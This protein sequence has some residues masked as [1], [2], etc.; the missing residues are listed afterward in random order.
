[1]AITILKLFAF[2]IS[3]IGTWEFIRRRTKID[4]NFLPGLT[5]AIQVAILF[6]AGLCHVLKIIAVVIWALGI[7]YFIAVIISDKNINFI[8]N[9][10]KVG[11]LFLFITMIIMVI[12]CVGKVYTTW[13]NFSH[14][15]IVVKQMFTTNAFPNANDAVIFYKEYPLGS[16]LYIY[17]F[18]GFISK[19]ESLQLLAQIY[20]IVVSVMPVFIFAKK[21]K[22]ASLIATFSFTNLFLVYNIYVTDLSVDTLLGIVG[23]STLFFIYTYCKDFA[24]LELKDKW[25]YAIA[26]GLYLIWVIQIK[27]SGIFFIIIAIIWLI[28]RVIKTKDLWARLV[29]MLMPIASLVAWRIHCSIAFID[30]DTSVHAMTLK[31]FINVFGT[32]SVSD[33]KKISSAFVSFALTYKDF[34]ITLALIFIIGV[35]IFFL[36]KSYR[37]T[38]L[39]LF[40]ASFI[41]YVL[42]QIGM[43]GMYF[44]SM[45]LSEALELACITRYTKTILIAMIFI[46][47][48]MTT[49]LISALEVKNILH[50][51]LII[52]AVALPIFFVKVCTGK[53]KFAVQYLDYPMT[54]KKKVEAMKD[55]YEIEEGSSYTFLRGD[56]DK[57]YVYMLGRSSF[58]STEVSSMKVED[59]AMLDSVDAKYIIILDQN[60]KEIENWVRENY[61]DQLGREVIIQTNGF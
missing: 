16:S 55:D 46:A 8:K 29:T 54:L 30:A 6:I 17:Y 37:K 53:F 33:L 34:W 61:P 25:L 22:I 58:L 48:I 26:A 60:N 18:A 19:S 44:F 38:V 23:I 49:S 52:I 5:V 1:M 35:M 41:L 56:E 40:I 4:V 50:L 36:Y 21:N 59:G 57:G 51:I 42:Y 3:N 2:L 28:Y 47:L 10:F 11:Y 24:S 27:N 14:W 32:K 45:P 12:F 7:V 13:D 39:K 15:G 9:Y 31:N 20:M 43:L